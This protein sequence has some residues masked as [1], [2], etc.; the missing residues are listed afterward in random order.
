MYI[1]KDCGRVFKET[2]YYTETHGF[3][4]P[5][6]EE[7]NGCPVCGGAYGEAH[8]CD[9][10]GEYIVGT[11]IKTRGGQRLCESCYD[12]CDTDTDK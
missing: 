10:C 3:E 1:C 12:Q 6:Y 9:C 11:Y 4:S 8:E 7:W 2:K 5:P